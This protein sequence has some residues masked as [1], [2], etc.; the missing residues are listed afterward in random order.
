MTKTEQPVIHEVPVPA[1]PSSMSRANTVAVRKQPPASGHP[2]RIAAPRRVT[3][4]TSRPRYASD[5]NSGTHNESRSQETENERLRRK[6]KELQDREGLTKY[7][8]EN[9]NSQQLRQATTE[10]AQNAA[11]TEE[12]ATQR[13]RV[14]SDTDRTRRIEEENA[15]ILAE[16]K[17][18]DLER[19]QRELDAAVLHPHT[20]KLRSVKSPLRSKFSFFSRK[21]ESNS[22]EP[23]NPKSYGLKPSPEINVAPSPRT[24]QSGQFDAPKEVKRLNEVEKSLQITQGGGGIV[25]QAD[26]PMSASNAGERVSRAI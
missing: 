4:P 19:L 1:I 25:P 13:R 11:T 2:A 23:H 14:E 7:A 9:E 22:S 15:S 5:D 24:L 6:V 17:R 8:E 16:Q 3:D 12:H 10:R 26:V 20:P 21:K 18:K